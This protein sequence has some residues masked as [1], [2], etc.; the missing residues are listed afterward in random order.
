MNVKRSDYEHL[1]VIVGLS[2]AIT[3]TSVIMNAASLHEKSPRPVGGTTAAADPR[4]DPAAHAKQA[5]MQEIDSRFNQ[6]V[7]MLHAKRYD[8]AVTA[9]HRVLQLSPRLPEAHLNMG[10]ALY[11][12]GNYPAARDFFNTAIE[13][14]PFSP[15]AYYGLAEASAKLEDFGMAVGAMSSYLHLRKDADVDDQF[16]TKGRKLLE[17]W[18]NTLSKSARAGG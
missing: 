13:L 8:M 5:R 10:Y 1:V 18:Q 7:M 11:G 6:A 15:N 17:E 4:A 14:D 16:V 2:V 9:L 3:I 12:A